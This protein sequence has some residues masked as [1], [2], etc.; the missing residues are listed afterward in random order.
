MIVCGCED[1]RVYDHY[2]DIDID[3]WAR[4]DTLKFNIDPQPAGMYDVRVGI[5]ATSAFPYE[6]ISLIMDCNVYAKKKGKW[7]S[8]GTKSDT[9]RC[10]LVSQNGSLQ[11]DNGIS[12][13]QML[14]YVMPLRLRQGDSLSIAL[15]HIMQRELMPGITEVGVQL[16]R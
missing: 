3:G 15:H 8:S 10:K 1:A 16:S 4:N 14:F 12:S 5:R 11:G 9:L 2:E 7:M 13:N 6:D